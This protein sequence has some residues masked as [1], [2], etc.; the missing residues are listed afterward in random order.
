MRLASLHL[1]LVL[2]AILRRYTWPGNQPH[3]LTGNFSFGQGPEVIGCGALAL[4]TVHLCP[5][6]S[7]VWWTWHTLNFFCHLWC[8]I[9]SYVLFDL[10][11]RTILW[12]R[13]CD[14]YL[15]G[16]TYIWNPIYGTNEPFHR[17]ENHGLENRLVVAKGDGEG[18]GWT[19]N[20]GL[21]D[22]NY[23]LWNG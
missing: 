19:R 9:G 16:I 7:W 2:D 21:I 23:C 3:S 4:K 5:C 15:Y 10:A 17:K 12:R 13:C 18:V 6:N 11:F 20:L 8:H 1:F 22:A 14:I